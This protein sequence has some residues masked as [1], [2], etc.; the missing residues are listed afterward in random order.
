MEDITTLH[1][2]SFSTQIYDNTLVDEVMRLATIAFDSESK[3]SLLLDRLTART[4]NTHERSS[5]R[6]PLDISENTRATTVEVALRRIVLEFHDILNVR[7]VAR[8]VTFELL[9]TY[10]KVHKSIYIY[11]RNTFVNV[12][13]FKVTILLRI[14]V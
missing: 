8:I 14:K 2:A 11:M 4:S 13:S 6:R 7:Q 5:D 12:Y 3:R 10:L 1:T 9:E